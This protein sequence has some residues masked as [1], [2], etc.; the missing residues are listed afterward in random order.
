MLVCDDPHTHVHAAYQAV[1]HSA[2]VSAVRNALRDTR[3]LLPLPKGIGTFYSQDAYGTKL[4]LFRA[5][6]PAA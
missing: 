4:T 2:C 1:T 5:H 3:E 6:S